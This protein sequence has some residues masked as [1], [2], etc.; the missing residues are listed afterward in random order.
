VAAQKLP[1]DVQRIPKV[2]LHRHLEG[3]VRASTAVE[4]L[5]G[6]EGA[7]R[8]AILAQVRVSD[9]DG[10]DPATFLGKF[11]TLRRVFR[12]PEV[13]QRVAREA[14]ADAAADRVIHLELYFTP[15]ALAH[16]G[17]YTPADV[18]GWVAEAA[19]GEAAAHGMSL[20]LIVSLNRHEPVA[21][22]EAALRA[23]EAHLGRGVVGVSLAGNE[24]EFPAQPFAGLLA[25]ARQAGFRLSVHAGEWSGAESVRFAIEDL[26]ADRIGHGIRVLESQAAADAARLRRIPF[27]VCPTSNLHSGA[28]RTAAEHP[29]PHMIQAGL[30][31][32]VNT[33][34]PGVS[35]I[36]LSDE[37]RLVQQA[38]GLTAQT[39]TALILAAA[40]AAF[41]EPRRKSDLENRLWSELRAYAGQ[42][43]R[44]AS[45]SP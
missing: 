22:G 39:V 25:E 15:A 14:V 18:T 13:I 16:T 23:A 36:S 44:S 38:M 27:E 33:D 45:E 5:A 3:S 24:A 28:V 42:P 7:E 21:S 32:T 9:G 20:G 6:S 10:R 41:L 19:L 8:E 35:G 4:A 1:L 12:S 31:V 17:G 29:L 26:Q 30:Q 34:D 40:Q 43:S 11:R 37:Y 2:D